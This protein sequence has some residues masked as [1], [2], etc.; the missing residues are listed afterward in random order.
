MLSKQKEEKKEGEGRREGRKKEG[1][2]R[3]GK[4]KGKKGEEAGHD[5]SFKEAKAGRY[6]WVQGQP[7][8]HRNID[9]D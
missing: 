4:E 6:L 5:R 1:E 9:I 2:E 3:G 8:L 7:S